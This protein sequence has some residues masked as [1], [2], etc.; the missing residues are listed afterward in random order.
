M[1]VFRLHL[2]LRLHRQATQEGEGTQQNQDLQQNRAP[3]VTW[4]LKGQDAAE[5]Y[6]K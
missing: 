4:Q 1:I 3:R 5:R 6:C 2:P